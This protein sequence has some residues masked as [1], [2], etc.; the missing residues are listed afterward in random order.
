MTRLVVMLGLIVLAALFALQNLEPVRLVFLGVQIVPL[1][2]AVWV[3]GAIA[4]GSATTL[5]IS[6][7]FHLSNFV[8]KRT[9]RSQERRAN[10]PAAEPGESVFS[11]FTE[12]GRSPN[13][14]RPQTDDSDASWSDWRGYEEPSQPSPTASTTAARTAP[15]MATPTADDDEDWDRPMSEDWDESTASPRR[16]RW[17]TASRAPQ[18]DVDDR[19]S[20]R[21]R[22]TDFEA[23]Q[24]PTR[25]SRSGSVYS[26]NYRDPEN[27]AD[28]PPEP[29]D[30]PRDR[31]RPRSASTSPTSDSNP[32]S[33]VPPDKP[34]VDADF[35]VIVPPYRNLDDE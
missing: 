8:T 17:D 25:S 10:R 32:T 19:T 14:S 18:D 15:P 11:R 4:A 1:P 3:L 29:Q 33:P 30:A 22:R 27:S 23:R 9:V 20:S 5:L 7:L 12:A 24:A 34:V 35:R 21:D 6:T 16:S 13:R 28:T 26:Y 31:D 2:L